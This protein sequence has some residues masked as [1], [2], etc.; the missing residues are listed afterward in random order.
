VRDGSL[1]L[2][3]GGRCLVART[4]RA[5]NSWERT[6][7]LLGRPPLGTGEA[8]LLDP[9][10]LVHTFGMRYALDLVFVDARG[11]VCKLAGNVRP[12]RFAGCPGARQTIE[13]AAGA[14]AGLALKIGDQVIW[15]ESPS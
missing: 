11:R 7:G 8:L 10:W 9:C 5:E 14:L 12:G 15:R 4:W 6:R 1:V 3:P 13:L 2:E